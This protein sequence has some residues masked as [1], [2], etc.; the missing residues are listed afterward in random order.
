LFAPNALLSGN[1]K[2][3]DFAKAKQ[4]TL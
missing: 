3:H 4:V 2:W 1:S